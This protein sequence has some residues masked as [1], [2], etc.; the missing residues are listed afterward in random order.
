MTR[1]RTLLATLAAGV[2]AFPAAAETLTVLEDVG[3]SQQLYTVDSDDPSIVS[4]RVSITGLGA[5]NE[6][7]GIDYRPQTG[8][9]YGLASSD[10]I[11]TLDVNTG[12]ATL[13]GSGFS[14]APNGTFFGFDFNPVIDKIRLVAD[15][16]TNFVAD[17]DTGDA[18][19]ADTTSLFFV[20]GDA[21]EGVNPN[22]V[23]IAYEN[24]VPNAQFTQLYAIDS[25]L[26]ILAELANNTGQLETV[27]SLGIDVVDILEFDISGTSGIG[28]LAAIERGN[29]DSSLYTVNLDTG[30]VTFLGDFSDASGS[31]VA[32]ISAPP[33]GAAVIPTPAAL[34]VGLALL[35]GLA[36]RRRT[37]A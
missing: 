33:P 2:V 31:T 11:Y 1:T 9:L 23:G 15:V 21:N 7:L 13:V 20:P 12:A 34:P 22:V 27:G 10:A 3:T 8:E 37:S 17:P 6:L 32:G 4:D 16:D 19:I 5:G 35:G 28:Y 36:L 18:N 24:S 14:D 25:E 29:T 26:D 30:S